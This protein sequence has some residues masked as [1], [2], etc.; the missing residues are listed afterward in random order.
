VL[1]QLGDEVFLTDGGVETDLIFNR[2]FDLPEFASFVVLDD[3]AGDAAVRAYFADYLRI[4]ATLG[5]GLVLE[6]VTW[7]ASA[8]WGAKLGYDARRLREVN[9]RSVDLLLD[10]RDRGA[11]T[12][13]V[14]SG[15]IGPRGDAYV[16]LGSGDADAAQRYHQA[17]VRTL[18][19]SGADLVS[20]LTITNS[21][22]AIGIAR[23]AAEADIPVVISFTLETDGALPT[24]MPLAD[25]IAAVD[26]A[27]DDGPV[28]Y[29]ANCVHPEHLA[30]A[31]AGDE[32]SLARL[33]GV[34]AN[35]SRKSHAE[36]DES[37]GLDDGNPAEL[38][39]ELAHLHARRPAINVLGG[40]CGTDSRHIE[41]IALACRG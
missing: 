33:R 40:C 19:E 7:R 13:V 16:G 14:V 20:A 1:P 25:A 28:Y 39:R 10:A 32:P 18:A 11:E 26:L 6:T 17:Q 5:Y 15:C 23:A 24:G 36:L 37:E 35:A 12:P 4:G 29:M 34:R 41:A 8:A 31:L 27:T 2:G 21:D 22:E 9:R 30:P 3:P 38:G